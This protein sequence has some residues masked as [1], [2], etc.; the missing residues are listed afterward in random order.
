MDKYVFEIRYT[1]LQTNT[2]RHSFILISIHKQMRTASFMWF[3]LT[4]LKGVLFYTVNHTDCLVQD[5]S[6]P[7]ALA[8]ELPQFCTTPLTCK[9]GCLNRRMTW[10]LDCFSNHIRKLPDDLHGDSTTVTSHIISLALAYLPHR[11]ACH[12]EYAHGM[13]DSSM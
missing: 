12:A 8:M 1:T 9:D 11:A 4:G 5:C 6:N 3:T 7:R 10:W 13:W 2:V